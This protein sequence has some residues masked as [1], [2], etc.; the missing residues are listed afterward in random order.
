MSSNERYRGTVSPWPCGT[1]GHAAWSPL[2]GNHGRMRDQHETQGFSFAGVSREG[3]DA[4]AVFA[5]SYSSLTIQGMWLNG[6]EVAE[7]G[8]DASI[9][10]EHG[11]AG[12]DGIRVRQNRRQ[13][14]WSGRTIPWKGCC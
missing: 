3:V 8:M 9:A 5:H 6:R 12:G 1:D 4:R 7:I 14:G 11:C 10:A 13:G 2:P